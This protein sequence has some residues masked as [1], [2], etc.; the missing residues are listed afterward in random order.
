MR[1]V[2]CVLLLLV[3]VCLLTGLLLPR[4]ELSG[5]S[6]PEQLPAAQAQQAKAEILQA[7]ALLGDLYEE[8]SHPLSQADIDTM[9]QHLVEAGYTVVDTDG[10]YPEYLANPGG[11]QAFWESASAGVDAAQ[12]VLQIN[13]SG[14]L[15]L[16]FFRSGEENR[17]LLTSLIWDERAEPV[18]EECQVLPIYDMVLSDWGIFYYRVYPADDPHYID[19]AQFWMAPVDR[20]A[21]DLCRTYIQ[22]V[23]YQMVNLFLCDWQ[24]G[25]WGQLSFNDLFEYLYERDTG[26]RVDVDTFPLEGYPPRASIPA[27]LFEDTLLPYFQISLEEF[28]Q[29]CGY[30][31]GGYPWRPIF[32]DDLTTWHFPICEPEVMEACQNADGTLTLTVQ[33]YSPELK[34]D[35]LFSHQVTVR[36]LEEGGFQYVSNRIT[37]TGPQGLPPDM[38]RFTLDGG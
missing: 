28:R 11:L 3:A 25:N 30:E 36:P 6:P 34:T 15:Y 2:I 20:E 26:Q 8:A 23:G 24:E 21:Y 4:A 22:T 7:S 13:S 18:V 10:V 38:S 9:E 12:S 19:Y 33:V 31:A 1:K 35:R 29:R 27:E 17:Y 16:R 5:W 14:F 32:G 37:Y